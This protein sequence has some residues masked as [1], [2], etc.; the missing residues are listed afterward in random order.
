MPLDN[1]NIVKVYC[2]SL[3]ASNEDIKVWIN[4]LSLNYWIIKKNT[5]IEE[6]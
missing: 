3:G 2:L 6:I 4:P 1:Y 5:E